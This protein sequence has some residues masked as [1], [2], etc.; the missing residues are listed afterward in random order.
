[1]DSVGTAPTR[2]RVGAALRTVE[3]R[4]WIARLLG[5][6]SLPRK[7]WLLAAVLIAPALLL[8]LFTSIYPF[9][10][11][12][13]TSFTNDSAYQATAEFIGLENYTALLTDRV[14]RQ[15][16]LF[17]IAFAGVSTLLELVL[18][19]ALALLLNAT[20]KLRGL[21]RA[22]ALIPWAIP[23]VVSALG[24]RFIFSDGFGIVPHLLGF[25]GIDIDW[26]TSPLPAQA[27]VI[28]ANVWRNVPFIAF[29]ILAGLQGVPAELYQAAKVDGAGWFRTM[30]SVVLPLVT[31]LLITMGVFMTIFQLGTFDT[32]FGMTGGGPGT[33][34]QVAPYLAYQE[35]FIGLEYGR[36]SALAMLLF[37]IVLA[38]G[39]LALRWFRRTEVEL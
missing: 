11:T 2:N 33:A 26:L 8:R 37:L 10:A 6:L 7:V 32:V 15:A 13:W 1:M 9:L 19:F 39:V 34:T 24:F 28:I 38:V 21:A 4:W 5:W 27:A 16:L 30:W 3:W 36:A 12:A 29:V 20:F 23:A 14:A 35:A 17:T 22:V 31:P 18:G 25:V